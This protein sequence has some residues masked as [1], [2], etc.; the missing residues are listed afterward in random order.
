MKKPLTILLLPTLIALCI[1]QHVY[2]D[3]I[4]VCGKLKDDAGLDGSVQSVAFSPDGTILASAYNVLV[5][6]NPWIS[7]R[8]GQGGTMKGYVV[9]WDVTTKKKIDTISC[10]G[11]VGC[12]TFSPDG[13]LL[14]AAHSDE[15]GKQRVRLL[16]AASRKN[17]YS[18]SIEEDK[19]LLRSVSTM[20]FSPDGKKFIVGT[21]GSPKGGELIIFDSETGEQQRIL[22]GGEVS[23]SNLSFSADGK[24]LTSI[25][26]NIVQVWDMSSEKERNSFPVERGHLAAMS[27]DGGTI[28]VSTIGSRNYPGKVA[29]TLHDAKTGKE[30]IDFNCLR[31][32]TAILFTPNGKNVVYGYS[33]I[34]VVYDLATGTRLSATD[35]PTFSSMAITP[36]GN[37][38]ATGN[39]S[40]T[41]WLWDIGSGK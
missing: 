32:G 25:S 17:R 2:A 40:G 34:I 37:L 13:K 7:K 22:K 8:S 26:E 39:Q 38:I 19:G 36:K 4:S 11:Y 10:S 18:L 33:G 27:P 23:V 21:A 16:D 28:A 35:G 6:A 1:S 9:L 5:G 12:V 30:Q 24:L 3:D 29:L 41:V 15:Q 20:T 14:A 31:S